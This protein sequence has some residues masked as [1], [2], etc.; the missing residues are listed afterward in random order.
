MRRR[1]QNTPAEG[2]GRGF[3]CAEPSAV[4]RSRLRLL[5][6]EREPE[7]DDRFDWFDVPEFDDWLLGRDPELNEPLFGDWFDREPELNEPLF[8]FRLEL[9]LLSNDR[10]EFDEPWLE[11]KLPKFDWLSF[12]DRFDRLR[13][14]SFELL[15]RGTFPESG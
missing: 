3:C 6:P 7:L 10:F 8:E 9:R 11:L 1:K 14:P 2:S 5:F 12:P 15:L 4:Q 13:L